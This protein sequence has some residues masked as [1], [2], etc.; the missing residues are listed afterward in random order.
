MNRLNIFYL[1]LEVKVAFLDEKMVDLDSAENIEHK[2]GE[3]LLIML[4]SV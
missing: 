2:V 3:S 4:C 1:V